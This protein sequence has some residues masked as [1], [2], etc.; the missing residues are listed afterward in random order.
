MVHATYCMIIRKWRVKATL[1]SGAMSKGPVKSDG[2]VDYN[3][4]KE[5]TKTAYTDLF[6]SIYAKVP[7]KSDQTM[8]SE[9]L[10]DVFNGILRYPEMIPGYQW[11]RV[12][13]IAYNTA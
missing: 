5:H 9:T 1:F 7:I 11:S 4:R 6:L 13:Q 10:M 2:K 3:W 12:R 8:N